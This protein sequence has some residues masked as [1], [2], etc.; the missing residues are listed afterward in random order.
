MIKQGGAFSIATSFELKKIIDMLLIDAESY[1]VASKASFDY[2]NQNKG[3]TKKIM[4][5]IQEKRL[6]TN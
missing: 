2:I 1:K 5:Y 3:A 6:L 4:N